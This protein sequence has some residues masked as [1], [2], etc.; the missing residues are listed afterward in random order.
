[1]ND[2]R[3]FV[4]YYAT[5]RVHPECDTRTLEIAYRNLAKT[6]HPDHPESADIDQFN[7]V[8]EAYRAVK[9]HGKRLAY[10]VQYSAHTGFVFSA[11]D[12]ILA[13][14]RTALSDADVHAEVLMIL[15]KRR[16]ERALEPGV[17]P[18]ELQRTLDCSNEALDFH[19]WYLKAKGLIETT[20]SGTLAI[21]IAGVD[22]VIT[23]SR[24]TAQEKLR[25]SQFGGSQ[26]PNNGPRAWPHA[27][28]A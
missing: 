18:Y 20:D 13:E 10:D 12:S 23:T 11:D 28:A 8:V 17:G 16:R 6:Y 25:I 7:A 15:Y 26:G 24:S 14:E 1:M 9:D 2:A 19:I 27:A 22:H 4:D 21:T 5:L 3:P